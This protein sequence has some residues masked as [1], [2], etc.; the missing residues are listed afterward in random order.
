MSLLPKNTPKFF[1][2]HVKI[3]LDAKTKLI[4][5][6]WVLVLQQYYNTN[7]IRPGKEVSAVDKVIFLQILRR[8]KSILLD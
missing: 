4:K 7:D 8:E 3:D 1:Y 6:N 5:L 2:S